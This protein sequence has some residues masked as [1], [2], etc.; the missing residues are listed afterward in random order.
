MYSFG[1]NFF[2]LAFSINT[3]VSL[4][5]YKI[6]FLLASNIIGVINP[7]P[8]STAND[9]SVFL[10]YLIKSSLICEF[11]YGTYWQAKL[12]ALIK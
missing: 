2:Y 1:Y 5:I 8:I 3:F 12:T 6:V 11:V 10:N 7:S 9:I 4:E